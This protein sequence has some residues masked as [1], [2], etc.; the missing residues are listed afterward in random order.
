MMKLIPY[1]LCVCVCVCAH[2]TPTNYYPLLSYTDFSSV[3]MFAN[4]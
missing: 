3:H 4:I 1:T 2:V